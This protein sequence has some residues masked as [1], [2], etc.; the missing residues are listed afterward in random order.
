MRATLGLMAALV[1]AFSGGGG[2]HAAGPASD[3]PLQLPLDGE[4]TDASW[5]A[6]PSADDLEREYPPLAQMMQL[7]GKA[8]IKCQVEVDGRLDD[9]HVLS[10]APTGLGFGAAAV[11]TAAYFSVKP[12]TLDGKPVVGSMTIPL[13][14]ALADASPQAP[15]PIPAPTSPGALPL[16]RQVVALGGDAARLRLTLRQWIEQESARIV[17]DGEAASGAAALDAFRQGL[18]DTLVED[19]E[20]RARLLAGRMSEADLRATAAYLATPAGKAWVAASTE[21]EDKAAQADFM[22]RFARAAR[23]HLCAKTDCELPAASPAPG[24]AP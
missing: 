11:R 15:T 20:R 10:E 19:L 5:R 6:A 24:A 21:P 8:T 9:C 4:A 18:E 7:P 1:L 17:V 3:A 23:A 16:A 22:S 14:F 13:R 12:A 2:A